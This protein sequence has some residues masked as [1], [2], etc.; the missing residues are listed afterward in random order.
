MSYGITILLPLILTQ[1]SGPLVGSRSS[2]AII[3]IV[4]SIM[5]LI[6]MISLC[7]ASIIY[8]YYGYVHNNNNY[9]AV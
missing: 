4:L 1:Y 6:W 7:L 8:S 5:A 2:L 3:S 9:G